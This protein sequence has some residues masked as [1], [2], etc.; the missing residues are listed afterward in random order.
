MMTR[1]LSQ[2]IIDYGVAGKGPAVVTPTGFQPIILGEA[3][4]IHLRSWVK[5]LY[6]GAGPPK[7]T[8]RIGLGSSD[9]GDT[10]LRR[11]CIARPLDRLAVTG[12]SVRIAPLN[13]G[14]AMSLAWPGTAA[15]WCRC[16]T[17]GSASSWR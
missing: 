3:R 4:W 10:H 17:A 2:P 9:T 8:V 5:R 14:E 7:W 1:L 6:P 13:T 16:S 15:R 11:N 12:M